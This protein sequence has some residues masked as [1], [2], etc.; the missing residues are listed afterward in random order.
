MSELNIQQFKTLLEQNNLPA[1]KQLLEDY[2]RESFA[3]PEEGSSM[4]A[5]TSAYLEASN[6]LNRQHLEILDNTLAMLKDL[7]KQQKQGEDDIDLALTRHQIS[8]S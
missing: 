2:F 6:S 4:L 7:D 1:A 8:K 5:V 3:S